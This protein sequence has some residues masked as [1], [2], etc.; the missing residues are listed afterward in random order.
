M[1]ETEKEER[2]STKL[3]STGEKAR[4]F[5]VSLQISDAPHPF[6]P[7]L[8]A[9]LLKVR[10]V[11]CLNLGGAFLSAGVA[12]ATSAIVFSYWKNKFR[13]KKTSM[14]AD[15]ALQLVIHTKRS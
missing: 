11:L 6:C 2:M 7:G 12:T 9:L 10:T 8:G 4:L 13:G 1:H 14:K 3:R 15:V 5:C